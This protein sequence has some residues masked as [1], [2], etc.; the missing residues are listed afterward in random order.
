MSISP[1]PKSLH[2]FSFWG[3]IWTD[4]LRLA[5]LLLRLA[6]HFLENLL[7]PVLGCSFSAPGAAQSNS[8]LTVDF[9]LTFDLL[10]VYATAPILELVF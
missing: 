9:W 1:Y 6:Q 10:T 7:V 4:P 3:F 5:Q 2:S 8:A